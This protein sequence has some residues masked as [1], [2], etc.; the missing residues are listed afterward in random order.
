MEAWAHILM[1]LDTNFAFLLQLPNLVNYFLLHLLKFLL[2]L[3]LRQ[4]CL[5]ESLQW[6]SSTK[7]HF[8]S[9][10]FP[11]SRSHRFFCSCSTRLSELER[12]SIWIWLT[13]TGSSFQSKGWLLLFFWFLFHFLNK[14]LCEKYK[15]M[16]KFSSKSVK[17]YSKRSRKSSKAPSNIC[18]K[19]SRSGAAIEIKSKGKSKNEKL[20]VDLVNSKGSVNNISLSKSLNHL[21]L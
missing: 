15:K 2:D 9:F 14:N 3:N 17:K 6:A 5:G 8:L 18:I 16:R 7:F 19:I 20:K 21:T 12:S 1:L 10:S 4:V 11:W 13:W